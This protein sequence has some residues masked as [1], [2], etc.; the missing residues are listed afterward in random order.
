MKFY[1][2]VVIY[3]CEKVKKNDPLFFGYL[4]VVEDKL[5]VLRPLV[6]FYFQHV[7]RFILKN[8]E[9]INGQ[10]YRQKPEENFSLSGPPREM[11]KLF[12]QLVTTNVSRSFS[13]AGTFQAELDFK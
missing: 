6:C 11:Q 12:P 1:T 2:F 7:F 5:Q 9:P 3:V 13:I 10:G 4:V 8:L